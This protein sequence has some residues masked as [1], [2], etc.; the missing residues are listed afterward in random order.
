MNHQNMKFLIILAFLFPAVGFA[1]GPNFLTGSKKLACEAKMCLT[2]KESRRPGMCAKSINALSRELEKGG[3]KRARRWL[4][5]CPDGD[6]GTHTDYVLMCSSEK[7]FSH[8][9]TTNYS[10]GDRKATEDVPIACKR[11]AQGINAD[12]AANRSQL[13]TGHQSQIPDA[14]FLP[15]RIMK[16]KFVPCNSSDGGCW[17]SRYI[18]QFAWAYSDKVP[19]GFSVVY[20]PNNNQRFPNPPCPAAGGRWNTPLCVG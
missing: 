14:V 6:D 8:L 17:R 11:F 5:S 16:W 3:S 2:E 18:K 7:I 4:N 10:N 9:Y 15:V 20:N 13:P 19:Q 12:L 1:S